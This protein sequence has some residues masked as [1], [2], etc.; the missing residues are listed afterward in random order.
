MGASQPA[1][2]LTDPHRRLLCPADKVKKEKVTAAPKKGEKRVVEV[3]PRAPKYKKVSSGRKCQLTGQKANNAMTVTFSH[4][5]NHKLQQVNLQKRKVYWPEAQRLVTLKV[6]TKTM[7]TLEKKGL[8]TMAEEAG[9]NLW[10]LPFTDVSEA[11]KKFLAEN[12][13]A[14]PVK[15]NPRQMKNPEKLA[16]SKKAPMQARYVDGRI[17]WYRPAM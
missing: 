6:S 7:K 16:A 10:K 5:R 1:H 8:T 13:G 2:S 3:D 9:I 11:R 15:K 17:E 4:K 14:V 12:S